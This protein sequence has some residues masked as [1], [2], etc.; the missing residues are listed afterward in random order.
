MKKQVVVLIAIVAFVLGAVACC[1]SCCGKSKIAVV[2]IAAIVS[3]SEQVQA[4]KNEQA[5]QAQSLTQWLQAAQD[6]V[7]KQTESKK[8]EELLQKYNAE[9]TQRRDAAAQQYA[10]R[11]QEVDNSIRQ[12]I[13]D[14]A[15]KGGYKMVVV[16]EV[17]I[18]G[19][20]DITE[21]VAKVVK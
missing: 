3:Q 10:A 6:E 14:V 1:L 11:L 8:K 7:E 16:K 20:K 17:V 5:A 12:T 9:F 13:I 2:D 19:G 4:L 18:D 21:E 15:K